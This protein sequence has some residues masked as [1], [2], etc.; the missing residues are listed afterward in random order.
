M[1]HRYTMRLRA[2]GLNDGDRFSTDIYKNAE[3]GLGIWD[4]VEKRFVKRDPVTNEWV[5]E[6]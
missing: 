3:E 5:P 4:T 6:T 2:V 1:E